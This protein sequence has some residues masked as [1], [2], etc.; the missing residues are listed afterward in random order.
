MRLKQTFETECYISEGGYYVIKQEN[1]GEEE[2]EST[3]LLSP[4][5]VESIIK[6]MQASMMDTSWWYKQDDF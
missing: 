6:H 2:F 4:L 3:I 1:P 5:Q